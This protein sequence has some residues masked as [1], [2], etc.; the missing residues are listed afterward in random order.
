MLLSYVDGR[1]IQPLRGNQRLL[2]LCATTVIVMMGQ[3]IISPVLPLYAKS[4]GVTTA[5][6]GLTISVFGAARLVLNLPADF[7]SE[8]FGRRLLL[9]GGPA[10]TAL[11][12]LLSGL[13]PDLWLLL[14][15]RFLAGAGSAMYMTGAMILLVDIWVR[16]PWAWQIFMERSTGHRSQSLQCGCLWRPSGESCDQG[17]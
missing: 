13:A 15:F 3:G 2:I 6:I 14:V 11:G 16:R 1:V 17:V 4:F 9:V 8:R 5:M 7:L 10:I 12:S